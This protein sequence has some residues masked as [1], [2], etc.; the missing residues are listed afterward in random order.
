MELE[1][2]FK[3]LK[4]DFSVNPNLSQDERRKNLLLLKQLL[5]ENASDLA[6]AVSSDFSYRPY[7]ETYLLEI[8][9]A[10]NAINY[11]LKHLKK[12]MKKRKRQVAWLFKPAHAYLLP[13]SLGV[14]GIIVPWNYPLLLALEPLIYALAAG[15]VV[16]IKMSELTPQTGATLSGLIKNSPLG[17]RVAIV[18]GDIEVSREFAGLP[19]AHL[20]FTG[21]TAVGK[22]IMEAAARNLTPVTL[23]LGGK[24]PALVS[25]TINPND[26]KRLFMGKLVNAGQTCIAPDYLLIPQGWEKR[27]ENLLKDF[28]A[29]HYPQLPNNGDYCS[30]ISDDHKER[31]EELIRDAR[32]KGADIVQIGQ[33]VEQGRKMPFFLLL[34]VNASM[35]VMQEEIFGP[36]FPVVAYDSFADAIDKINL[37][38]NPLVIYYFGDDR[39]EKEMLQKKTLS[40]ALSIN[41]TLTHVAID[42]LPFGGVGA[43][44]MGHYHGQEGFDLFSKLKPVFVQKRLSPVTWFYPPHG[45][46]VHYLL[47]WIA[48]IRLKEKK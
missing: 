24:S 13:Q 12:W 26:F 40:G 29:H 45:K 37:L 8:F 38:A 10:L 44:G 9:I 19:F 18:N 32:E 48:G 7:Y 27:I 11:C 34:N 35:R 28:I 14:T 31:L 2:V 20:L 25:K 39:K 47:T 22:K 33:E 30:V 42:D 3:Q 4:Q 1:A 21:S 43:S 16:M 23:E 36:V 6:R 41:D 5:Q 15:N 46:L 17:R